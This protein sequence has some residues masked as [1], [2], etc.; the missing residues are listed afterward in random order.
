MTILMVTSL[1]EA[2]TEVLNAFPSN[3]GLSSTLNPA[4]IVERNP[5]FNFG[6]EMIAFAYYALVRES[7]N[8]NMNPRSVPS[9]ALKRSNNVEWHYFMSLYY[10]KRMHGC[11]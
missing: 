5:K 8:N 3:T 10:S 11:K 1:I 7:S 4:N 6:K 2:M 9:I